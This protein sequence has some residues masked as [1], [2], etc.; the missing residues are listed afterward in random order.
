MKISGGMSG[1]ILESMFFRT[2]VFARRN[3]G[4]EAVLEHNVTGFLFENP[5]VCLLV[6]V[7]RLL[8]LHTVLCLGQEFLALAL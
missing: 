4:N 5:Q 8:S 6:P 2:P 7:S 3:E 1:A